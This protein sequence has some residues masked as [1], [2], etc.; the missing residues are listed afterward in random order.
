[1]R[2][3]TATGMV[4]VS[5]QSGTRLMT[6]GSVTLSG[7]ATGSGKGWNYDA[8]LS[9]SWVERQAPQVSVQVRGRTGTRAG[10]IRNVKVSSA[11]QGGSGASTATI[12]G[13]ARVPSASGWHDWASFSVTTTVTCSERPCELF[14]AEVEGKKTDNPLGDFGHYSFDQVF[15][16]LKPGTPSCLNQWRDKISKMAVY[17]EKDPKFW[18]IEGNFHYHDDYWAI[19][20]L[21]DLAKVRYGVFHNE[22]KNTAPN[23]SV[24]CTA[25]NTPMTPT[26]WCNPEARI[27]AYGAVPAEDTGKIECVKRAPVGEPGYVHWEG[28]CIDTK[29]YL[30]ASCNVIPVAQAASKKSCGATKITFYPSS[31][32]SLMWNTSRP[33]TAHGSLVQFA[34]DKSRSDNWY[35]WHGSEETPLL[36]YD[37]THKG[38]ITSPDQ[39]FGNWT[40]GGQR[41]ATTSLNAATAPRPWRDGYEALETLDHNGDGEISGAELEPLALWFDRG[42]DAVVGAGEVRPITDTGVTKLFIGPRTQN[43]G[44][45]NIHVKQGYTVSS[46]GTERIGESVD[47]FSE[48]AHTQAELLARQQFAARELTTLKEP[49]L[50]NVKIEKVPEQPSTDLG[51]TTSSLANDPRLNGAWYWKAKEDTDTLPRGMLLITA[52]TGRAISGLAVTEIPVRDVTGTVKVIQTMRPF[53]GAVVSREG[54]RYRVTFASLLRDAHGA[55]TTSSEAEF[56]L[57][58]GVLT[59]RTTE[60]MAGDSKLT[61]Q[62]EATK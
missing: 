35:M 36:V 3:S 15:P 23:C 54:N 50:K 43:A 32:I 34:L 19:W 46:N 20:F 27:W 44:T 18:D 56:D 48:G 33:I 38:A 37:P 6:G 30:D 57:D 47:W 1:M 59:G 49:D 12:T 4:T 11:A 61:Y 39:L 52:R 24:P 5:S 25:A 10:E 16:P 29:I 14:V 62:W 9:V 13:Q 41:S 60:S 7:K 53:T 55:S 8:T 26:C 21:D 28:G 40:F 2:S 51:G 42:A 45:R 17:T 22:L 31:P 58:K